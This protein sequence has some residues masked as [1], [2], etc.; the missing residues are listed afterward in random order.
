[1]CVP[2]GQ[3]RA[4][5][6][7]WTTPNQHGLNGRSSKK[8]AGSPKPKAKLPL[9]LAEAGLGPMAEKQRS[10]VIPPHLFYFQRLIRRE[11]DPSVPVREARNMLLLSSKTNKSSELRAMLLL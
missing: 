3:G 4:V 10:F 1:M 6:T 8:T 5:M 9:V 11:S 7:D 2:C